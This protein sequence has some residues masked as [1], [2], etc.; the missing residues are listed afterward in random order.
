VRSAYYDAAGQPWKTLFNAGA[1]EVAPNLWRPAM[2]EMRDLKLNEVTLIVFDKRELNS[3]L[4]ESLFTQDQ[5]GRE[6]A[7]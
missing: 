4:P 6:I 2:S 7:R 3:A 1:R 5:L